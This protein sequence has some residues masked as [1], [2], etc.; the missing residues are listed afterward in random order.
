MA[1]QT[2]LQPEHRMESGQII[3]RIRSSFRPWLRFRRAKKRRKKEKKKKNMACI[4]IVPRSE[5]LMLQFSMNVK[6]QN[7]QDR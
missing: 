6:K 2:A 3:Q 4:V 5:L 7:K 1:T